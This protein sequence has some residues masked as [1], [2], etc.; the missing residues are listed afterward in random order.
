MKKGKK[1]N[2]FINSIRDNINVKGEKHVITLKSLHEQS[3]F[4]QKYLYYENKFKLTN[5][6]IRMQ[7]L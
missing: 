5:K 1:L 4:F 7:D 6:Q 3:Y 2:H